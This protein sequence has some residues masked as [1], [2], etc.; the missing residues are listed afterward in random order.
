MRNL[1]VSASLIVGVLSGASPG[2]AA[3]ADPMG[4][5]PAELAAPPEAGSLADFQSYSGSEVVV[6]ISIEA[7]EVVVE[8]SIN[9]RGPF[10]FIFDTGAQDALTP[11]TVAALGLKT[12]GA[13]TLQDSGSHSVSITSTRVAAIRLGGLEMT[14]QPFFVVPL[15]RYLTDRGNRAPLAGFIGYELLARFAVRLDY[16]KRSLTLTPDSD[17]R[18]DGEG[19]HVPLLFRDKT[20]AVS[21]AADGIAGFFL[22]DTGSIGALTLRREYV[23]DHDLEARHPSALGIKSVGA[24]GSFDTILS[25]L[26]TF[27]VAESRI[28]RPA[29]RFPSTATEGLPFADIAGSI[30]Y[31]ILRQFTITFDYGRG[32]LW[33]ERSSAFGARTGQG[34]AGFQAVKIGGAG[35][36]VITVLPDAAASAAGLQ[37][38]DVITE[39]DGRSTASMSMSELAEL[40][41]QPVGTSVRLGTI[42]DGNVLTVALTLKDVLP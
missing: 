7:G 29:T 40:L 14:D 17:F 3:S 18:H 10:P 32:E 31:E 37:V 30:G 22:I 34:G 36:G 27:D 11:E 26:D 4:S 1:V 25:R 21:A 41:R 9:G 42:R 20:P 16:D 12:E 19:V 15:P 5:A 23:E 8:A 2:E 13:G 28:D 39:V 33:F 6:P 24:A 35:F 38:G